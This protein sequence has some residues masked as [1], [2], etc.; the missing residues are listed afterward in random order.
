MKDFCTFFRYVPPKAGPNAKEKIVVDEVFISDATNK[1]EILVF[2]DLHLG[3]HW[4][5]STVDE[6]RMFLT[7]LAKIAEEYVHTL[8]MLGDVFE[9]WM[10]PIT[11][12]PTSKEEYAESW[13]SHKVF[14]LKYFL[15]FILVCTLFVAVY[16][17]LVSYHRSISTDVMSFI[18]VLNCSHLVA[19]SLSCTRVFQGLFKNFITA[20]KVQ[21]CCVKILVSDGIRGGV[22]NFPRG[23]NSSDEGAEMRLI[24]YYSRQ[25]SPKNSYSPS[26]GG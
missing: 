19:A 8:V 20:H 3:G 7:K 2:S 17:G 10:S 26:D 5:K 9:M 21:R 14:I 25:T 22:R 6:M 16:C 1:R 15:L 4:S 11:I 12:T 13:K 18:V 24:G 23:A